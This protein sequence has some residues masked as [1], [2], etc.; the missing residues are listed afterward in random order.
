MLPLSWNRQVYEIVKTIPKG[1]VVTY[2]DIALALNS[3]DARRVGWALHANKD[4]NVPCHRVVTKD[5]KIAE[6]FAFDGALEQR[7]RLI[8]EGVEFVDDRHV[9]LDI[10]RFVFKRG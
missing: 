7:R 3:R 1:K 10:F 2:G 6:N 8:E 9:K 5:G 4:Q